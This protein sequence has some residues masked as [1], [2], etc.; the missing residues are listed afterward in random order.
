MNMNKYQISK[1]H[2]GE[3][4]IEAVKSVLKSGKL[5]QGEKVKEFE[6][7]FANF[8]SVEHAVAVSSG[9]A[10]LHIALKAHG[11]GD[12]GRDEVITSPL[13]FISTA[14]SILFVGA[15]PVFADIT[16]DDFNIN[17][18]DVLEKITSRTRAIIPVHLYGHPAEMKTIMEIAEDHKLIVIEDACQAHGAEYDG[19]KAGSFGAGCFSFYPTKNMT[20]GE[21]GMITTKDA[22]VAELARMLRN[23]G[24]TE[25]YLHE[26]LGYNFRMTDINAAIGIEQLKKLPEFTRIRQENASY[27]SKRLSKLDGII[28]PSVKDKCSHVFHQYTTRVVHP[29]VSRDEL[30]DALRRK[31][32]ETAIYYPMPIY[33]QPLYRNLGYRDELP[34]AEK[35]SKEV[36]SL[37]VHP[38]LLKEDRDYVCDAIEE[39]LDSSR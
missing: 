14:N 9:T 26:I 6:D 12:E 15:K 34:M 38:G 5:A 18:E 25:K 1:P 30:G 7:L 8:I 11:V 36:L 27:L 35:V 29:S 37:P 19:K 22:K 24:S 16:E 32:V 20:T 13:S 28:T 17:P 3:E 33:K 39:S 21:G 10:A 2:I 4:E 31:G 23:H